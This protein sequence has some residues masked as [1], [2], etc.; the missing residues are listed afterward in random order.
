MSSP[1]IA[2][3]LETSKELDRLRKEE[4]DVLFE[5]NKMHKKLQSSPDRFF[6]RFQDVDLANDSP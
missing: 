5:I 3:I 2:V 6:V 1:D 4:E